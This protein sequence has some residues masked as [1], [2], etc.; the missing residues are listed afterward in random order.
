M[1]RPCRKLAVLLLAITF[2]TPWVA[3]AAPRSPGERRADSAPLSAPLWSALTALWAD[4]GC[5]IDPSG[6]CHGDA[7]SSAPAPPALPDLGCGI[8]PNGLCGSSH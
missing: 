6:G 1:P 7:Q 8:D 2:L 5:T 3:S 4:L